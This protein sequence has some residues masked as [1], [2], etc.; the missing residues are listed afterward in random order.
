M[1][2][3]TLDNG[4]LMQVCGKLSGHDSAKVLK[5]FYQSC[6]FGAI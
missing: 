4:L 6:G 2:A 1:K 3:F 5:A